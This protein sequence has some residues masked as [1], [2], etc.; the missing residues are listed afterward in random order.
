MLP[1]LPILPNFKIA[2][3]VYVVRSIVGLQK[4]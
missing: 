2:A 4:R 3:I 1:A